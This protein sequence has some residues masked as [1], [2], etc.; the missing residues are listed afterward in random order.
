VLTIGDASVVT[1][2]PPIGSVQFSAGTYAVA[3]NAGAVSINI[4]RSGGMAGAV[5]VTFATS[6]GTGHAGTNYTATTQT[7]AFADA[8]AAAKIVSVPVEL[9]GIVGNSFTVNLSL[10]GPA[11]GATLGSPATAVL[12]INA[13]T[14]APVPVSNTVTVTGKGGGGAIGTTEILLLGALALLR[15]CFIKGRGGRSRG[16]LPGFPF[17]ALLSVLG[18]FGAACPATADSP[19]FYAGFGLGQVRSDASAEDLQRKLDAAGF[20]GATVSI[21]DRK[22]GG[23][24]YAGTSVNSYLA[25]EVAYVDLNRV[26]TRSTAATADVAGFVA[27]VTAIHPYSARG[28]SFTALA[29]LPVVGGLAV[30]ARGGGFVWHGEID[31]AIPGIDTDS[32][33]KTGLA[34]VVGA[35]AD[36]AFTNQLALRAE[37][38]RYFLTRDS[39]DLATFGLRYRF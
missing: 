7:V 11:G 5:T 6:D 9:H 23:K 28:G 19:G 34:G 24:V 3:D 10:T 35:G 32:T 4:T 20:P 14:S 16:V 37:W 13:T 22:P 36:F 2:P 12:T 33:R 39:M 15:L 8:D 27:A 29:S 21:D 25:L 30:F 18:I 31:A 1:P 26:R 17:A 38:E